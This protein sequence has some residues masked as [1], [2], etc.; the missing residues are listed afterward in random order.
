LVAGN[1]ARQTGWM[2]ACG[3]KLAAQ[4]Q[5]DACGQRYEECETGL[6]KLP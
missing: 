2:C 6:R 4:L 5:C 3:A 1:P